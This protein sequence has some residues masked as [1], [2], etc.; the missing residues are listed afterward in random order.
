MLRL[1]NIRASQ[2][3]AVGDPGPEGSIGKAASA[4]LNKDIYEL[5]RRPAGR[6]RDAHSDELPD[7]AARSTPMQWRQPPQ[8]AF[9]R[10]RANSIEGGTTEI[11]Q[12]ILGERVLGLPGDVRDD[13]DVP[14][15][16]CPVG[17][18][19]E[20]GPGG[21]AAARGRFGGTGP[22]SY[23]ERR[24]ADSFREWIDCARRC[25]RRRTR[26]MLV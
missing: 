23:N 6:R 2:H 21:Q 20:M 18:E 22:S 4:E 12:N 5:R 9:L 15:R 25:R 19:L 10:A 11:T 17:V 26:L 16:R 7:A 3:R 1:T 24:C 8:Q 14:G 13:K